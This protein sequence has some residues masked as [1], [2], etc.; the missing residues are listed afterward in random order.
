MSA[1]PE[2]SGMNLRG[3][4]VDDA[5]AVTDLL[6]GDTALALQ[7]ATIPIPYTIEAARQF[8]RT[9][10]P[11]YI[12][13]VIVGTELVGMIGMSSGAQEPVEVGY[14]MG[15]KYWGRGY[16]T[17]AVGLLL[18][19]AQRR[20]VS[21]VVSE[22]FPDNIASMRVLQ[23]NGFTRLGEVQK[24]LPQRGGLRQLIFFGREL[25]V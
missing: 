23:K 22:V 16:A 11:H 12:F 19:E 8:L 5:L 7:T 13:A 17:E 25:S 18:A 1:R 2:S 10:D 4:T 15:R 3:A 20:G 9:A 6:E 21:R 24:D 14:W